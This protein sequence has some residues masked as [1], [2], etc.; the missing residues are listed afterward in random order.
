MF[1]ML[2]TKETPASWVGATPVLA[3]DA[4]AYDALDAEVLSVFP[5]E[6]LITPADIKGENATVREG[7]LANNWPTLAEARGRVMIG[8]LASRESTEPY[9]NGPG[10]I[11]ARPVG[12]AIFAV[13]APLFL[14]A[15]VAGADLGML[16]LFVAVYGVVNGISTVIRGTIVRDIFG[17]RNYGAI[18]GSMTMPTTFARA[19]GPAIGAMLWSIGQDYAAMLAGL[20]AVSFLG[21]IAFWHATRHDAGG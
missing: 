7:V 6:A 2:N 18:S 1:I 10:G 11:A 13:A 8:I 3:F 17:A 12:R 15:V 21:A 19:G 14:L 20:A 4:A 16:A 5:R 9:R